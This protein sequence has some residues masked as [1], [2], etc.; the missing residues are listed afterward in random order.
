M[1]NNMDNNKIIMYG[2]TWCG[3]SRR[4]KRF[5]EDNKIEFEFINIDKDPSAENRVK[6]INKGYKSVP[7]IIFPDGSILVEPDN[8][9]LKQKLTDLGFLN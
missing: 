7:T 4:A 1:K 3:D 8:Q 9:T 5:F 6:E 2:T